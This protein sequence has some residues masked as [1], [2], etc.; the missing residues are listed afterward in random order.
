MVTVPRALQHGDIIAFISPSSRLNTIFSDR[1]H[2]AKAFFEDQLGF[3]VKV[4]YDPTATT[5]IKAGAIQRCNEIHDAFK[6]PSIKAIIC[7]IGGLSANELL[8]YLDFALIAANPK[9]FVGYSDITLLHYAFYSK[10]SLRTFYGPAVIP[11]FGEYPAVFSLT[12]EHFLHVLQNPASVPVGALPRSKEWT[13][14]FLDWGTP[15]SDISP[16]KMLPSRPWKWLRHGKAQGRIFGG[17]LPSILQ[18]KGTPYDVNYY[19]RILLLELPEGDA[20]PGKPTPVE[21]A[22]LMM[23]DLV[24]A[25]V[26]GVIKGLV[27]GRPYMYDEEMRETLEKVVLDVL[28]G[29]DCPILADVDVGHTDPILTIPLDA[30]VKLDSER[31]E[32]VV[33]ET[34]VECE[35]PS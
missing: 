26:L 27:I 32:F 8:P 33:E 30:L 1:V 19:G 25:G 35:R 2:R 20:G 12:L 18:L 29:T 9:I 13:E 5:S 17:C 6:D 10:A 21:N 34:A 23:S 22:R 14:E 16:R 3:H 28:V 15:S 24:N 7:T 31:D 11:Q 4:I